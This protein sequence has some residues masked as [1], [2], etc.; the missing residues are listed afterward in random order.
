M[1]YIEPIRSVLII[2]DQYPTWDDWL[3]EN[4][5]GSGSDKGD[6][7]N[8]EKF[9]NI[10]LLIDKIREIFPAPIVDIDNGKR[11]EADYE[12]YLHQSDL[13]ILDYELDSETTKGEKFLKIAHT[14]LE[15]SKHFNLILTH[16][17]SENLSEPFA[18]LLRSFLNSE[19]S[20]NE[21][22]CDR[23]DE[24]LDKFDS[25]TKVQDSISHKQYA[26][27][28]MDSRQAKK[29][30]CNNEAP[31]KEFS[32]HCNFINLD[33]HKKIALL[34]SL[35]KQYQTK[36]K[37]EFRK[38]SPPDGFSCS[39][40]DSYWI[41]TDRGFIAFA[42]KTDNLEEV[43][44]LKNAL[45]DWNPTPSRLLSARLRAEI[46]L[47]GGIFEDGFLSDKHVALMFY[48]KLL[49]GSEHAQETNLRKEIQR[50][51]EHYT[52]DVSKNLIAF[53]KKIVLSDTSKN[54]KESQ[55]SEAYNVNFFDEAVRNQALDHFNSFVSCK[56]RTGNHLAPGHIFMTTNE[57]MWVVLS[58]ACD[59][60]PD[61][62]QP[63]MD[64][65]LDHSILSFTAALLIKVGNDQARKKATSYNYVFLRQEG[66]INAYNFYDNDDDGKAPQYRT[67]FAKKGGR[68]C[69][70]GNLQLIRFV[71]S[72]KGFKKESR[73]VKL[74]SRQLRYEY[75]L[76]LMAK[77]SA[78]STRIG[79]EFEDPRFFD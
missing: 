28:Y 13:L 46:E 57:E 17:H 74:H 4:V 70:D 41:K 39:T 12:A 75:A 3:S 59:L 44:E 22:L 31:F 34:M 77:L 51:M 20:I 18:K 55:Y 11:S 33:N 21:D 67:F 9:E 45:I 29:N 32:K 72:D 53:G 49:N 68:I 58:P 66:S 24:I 38:N 37:N 64:F 76:N 25:I 2:D 26:A 1:A 47:Q 6:G 40:S 8:W 42:K 36:Y 30:V 79:L 10:K 43:A 35:L 65:E 15:K 71:K 19:I 62:R 78:H 52:E 73:K 63:R 61:R 5:S 50:Q 56:P 23:G 60:V 14:L 16:T 7:Q 27:Y 48:Q 69:D 54:G